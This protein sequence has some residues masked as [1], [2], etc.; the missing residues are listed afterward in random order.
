MS[1]PVQPVHLLPSRAIKNSGGI[2][3][4]YLTMVKLN[5]LI[6]GYAFINKPEREDTDN[7]ANHPAGNPLDSAAKHDARRAMKTPD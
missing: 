6:D 7:G 3:D 5:S 2:T 4:N 1:L